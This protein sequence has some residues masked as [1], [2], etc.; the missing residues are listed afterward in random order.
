ML[1]IPRVSPG[2]HPYES[3]LLEGIIHQFSLEPVGIFMLSDHP[4]TDDEAPFPWIRT[5][6]RRDTVEGLL[7]PFG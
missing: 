5:G 2:A 4:N 7:S 6:G 1:W 3:H